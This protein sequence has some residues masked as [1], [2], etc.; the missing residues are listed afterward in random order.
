VIGGGPAGSSLALRLA[1]LSRWVILG[2]KDEFPRRHVGESLTGSILSLLDVLAVLPT[3]ESAG[4]LSAAHAIV[5]WGSQL[6]RRETH[7]GY[8]VDRGK[9]DALLHAARRA[10][11]D[12]RQPAR[13]VQLTHRDHWTLTLES[14]RILRRYSWQMEPADPDFYWA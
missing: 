13:I 11:V 12:V 4:F 6:Q 7:G 5:F 14:G 8:Q 3:S 1:A 10:G 2:E 9:Y